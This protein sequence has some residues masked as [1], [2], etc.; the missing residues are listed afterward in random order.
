[1]AKEHYLTSIDIPQF[2]RFGVGFEQMLDD[3]LHTSDTT[4]N[5]PPYNIIQTGQNQYLIEVAISGFAENEIDVEVHKNR[6]RISG[7]KQKS[8]NSDKVV[9]KH[10]GIS[11]R[12]FSRV[13]QLAEHVEVVNAEVKNGI[14]CVFL[15][16]NLP[17]ENMP[18]KIAITFKA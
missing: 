7:K 16:Q 3:M 10:R 11:S 14:L 18:K 6:L 13:F 12:D 15:E 4:G 9:Y 17:V 2:N 1:M 5:Y 8:E